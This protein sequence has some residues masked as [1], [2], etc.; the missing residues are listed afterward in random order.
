ML[1]RSR[2]RLRWPLDAYDLGPADADPAAGEFMATVWVTDPT[3]DPRL[4]AEIAPET[5]ATRLGTWIGAVRAQRAFDSRSRLPGLTV[6]TLVIWA[7][8]D[9]LFPEPDQRRVR[10]ALDGAIEGCN[11]DY[12]FY[13]TY[14]KAPLPASGLQETDIGHNV[15]W[16][17][18]E[19][20][21]ADLAAWV[22]T[23]RPTGDLP[24]ADPSDPFRV[25]NDPGGA[26]VIERRRAAT[27][28]ES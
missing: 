22:A 4:L 7:T 18:H 5:T 20:I 12:Y 24:F 14:G 11:L 15:Q 27:C 19:A 10:D 6:P 1:E 9:A 26:E 8:Q 23:S 16:G 2:P 28:P 3:A 17:A 21:A 13:K 25:V